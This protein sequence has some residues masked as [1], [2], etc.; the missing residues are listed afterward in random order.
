MGKLEHMQPELGCSYLEWSDEQSRRFVLRYQ[1]TNDQE[2][3]EAREENPEKS[4]GEKRIGKNELR[5][6][7]C[8][9]SPK[10]TIK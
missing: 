9:S 1:K 8:G 3:T 5:S 2:T 7:R 4:L 10:R 6:P